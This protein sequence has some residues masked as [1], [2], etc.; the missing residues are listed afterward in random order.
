[1][2]E[3]LAAGPGSEPASQPVRPAVLGMLLFVTS[4]VMFFGGLFA[5]Y[6]TLRAQAP[7]WPP[8]GVHLELALPLIGTAVLLASSFTVHRA[9]HRL[10]DGQRS[11]AIRGLILTAG[12]GL[13]FLVIQAVEYS[14]AGFAL[15]ESAYATAFFT[16]TGFHGLHVAIGVVMLAVAA[17]Q[18]SR[19]AATP[20]RPG[21][22]EATSLYWHFVDGVWL[23]V[24]VIVYLIG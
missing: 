3:A 6:L 2:S 23:L 19:R 8:A 22:V 16:L 12:L 9:V 7:Q 15:G 10:G 13:I 14:Q 24:L 17:L 20:E 21:Q 11:E 1:M 5:L 4:E 18:V